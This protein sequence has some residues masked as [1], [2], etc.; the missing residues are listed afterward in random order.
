MFLYAF[1]AAVT[2]ALQLREQN[3]PIE[4]FVATLNFAVNF[5][6]FWS[7][8]SDKLHFMRVAYI[9]N[10]VLIALLMSCLVNATTYYFAVAFDF[11]GEKSNAGH[12][13]FFLGL[14]VMG[15][16]LSVS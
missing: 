2:L 6:I 12:L 4:L 16:S 7:A 11:N 5:M 10:V 9:T 15:E 3:S 8:T 1:I 14:T 13:V